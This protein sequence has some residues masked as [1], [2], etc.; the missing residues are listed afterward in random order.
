MTQAR[1]AIHIS[2]FY[3]IPLLLWFS[4]QLRFIDW[5]NASLDQF[6]RQTQG[7]VILL[8]VF[9]LALLF[10]RTAQQNRRDELL[11]I[12]FVTLYPLPF[13]AIVW[14]TGGRPAATLLVG[15][16]LVGAAGGV[17]LL[18]RLG[19]GLVPAKWRFVQ[20]GRALAGLLL[21]ALAWNFRGAWL[22]MLE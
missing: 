9:A 1:Q 16:A 14:L 13:L 11:S 4:A 12:L 2:V 5:N 6:C 20:T 17:V 15:L 10:T 18:L 3:S 21:A 7:V 19:A 8:Q 22:G